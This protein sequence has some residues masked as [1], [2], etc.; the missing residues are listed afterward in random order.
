[1]GQ[2]PG[3]FTCTTVHHMGHI[4]HPDQGDKSLKGY[5]IFFIPY[6]CFQWLTNTISH[7]TETYEG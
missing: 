7:N 4:V 5:I 3:T 2:A 1:M 6:S